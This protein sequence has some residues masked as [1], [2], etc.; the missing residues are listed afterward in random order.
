MEV[1]DQPYAGDDAFFLKKIE[2]INDQ[3]CS[4]PIQANFTI[5][6]A[7]TVCIASSCRRVH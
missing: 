3:E 1:I 5:V 7:F 2:R 4:S 6:M